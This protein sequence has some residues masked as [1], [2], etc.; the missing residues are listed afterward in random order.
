MKMN[1]YIA[2]VGMTRFGKHMDTTLKGLAGEAIAEALTDAGIEASAIEAAYM[3][4]AAGGVVQGQEMIS[5]QVALR[6]LGIGRIP[7]INL[8]NACASSSTAFNQACTMVSLGAYDIALVCGFEKLFH[9]DKRRTFA[10]FDGAVDTEN[11]EGLS[12]TLKTLAAI[13]GEEVDEEN[14]GITRSVFMDIYS[15]LAK[16]HM[17]K[18]GTTRE[19]FA[20]VTVKNSFHG[21]LNPRAQFQ[22]AM[23]LAEVLDS[24]EII[25]PLTL[26]MCSPIGDGAAAIVLVSQRKARELGL[27]KPVRVLSSALVSGWDLAEGDMSVGE[28]AAQQAYEAA[29][30]GPGEIS[31]AELHDASAPSEVIAYDYLGI[32][33]K[34]QGGRLIDDGSTRLGGRI[35]VNV[36]GGLLRKGHP[37][38]ATGA[39]QIVE[40]TEQLQGRSNQRQV[41]NARIGLTHNGGGLIGLDAAATVVTILGRED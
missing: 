7:V 37:I 34:G 41:E 9:E 20:G 39:A 19:Q 23:T 12:G 27:K 4:N 28:F 36:S 11:P 31:L 15:L 29:G 2:G 33:E 1:A 26:P 3:A 38:G 5:G 18:Y 13:A 17:K 21:S 40:I 14:A 6:E 22:Q 32:C 10:A 24:R 25:D 35:P 8:E 16:A 30:V